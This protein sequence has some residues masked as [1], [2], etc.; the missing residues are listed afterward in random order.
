MGRLSSILYGLTKKS[1][2]AL[3]LLPEDGEEGWGSHAFWDS[4][5]GMARA[6][7]CSML[8]VRLAARTQWS[9]FSGF[10]SEIPERAVAFP[11]SQIPGI[12][13]YTLFSFSRQ[14]IRT[15]APEAPA[16]WF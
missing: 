11:G 13:L 8:S 10:V 7:N 9:R 16:L 1:W 6:A 15:A 12:N 3:R 5:S 14:E 2:L 4:L